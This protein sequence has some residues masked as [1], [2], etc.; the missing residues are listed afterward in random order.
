MYDEPSPFPE[1]RDDRERLLAEAEFL[2]YELAIS[3]PSEDTELRTEI[4]MRANDFVEFLRNRL[5]STPA[6]ALQ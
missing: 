1:T 6:A 2:L 4:L 3:E 5:L